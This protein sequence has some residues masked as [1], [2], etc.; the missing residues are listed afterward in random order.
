[1]VYPA[2]GAVTLCLSGAADKGKSGDQNAERHIESG[3]HE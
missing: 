1:M 2:A 3:G